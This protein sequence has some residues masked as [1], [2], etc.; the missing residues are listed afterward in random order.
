MPTAG[1]R[2]LTVRGVAVRAITVRVL[3]ARAITVRVVTVRAVAVPIV[4]AGVVS[5]IAEAPVVAVPIPVPI[6]VTIPVA[7]LRAFVPFVVSASMARIAH[8][9]TIAS[10]GHLR[11][12]HGH[13]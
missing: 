8:V 12:G 2:V 4:T 1:R 5:T 7:P 10:G 3:T 11:P 13:R 6:P 9:V